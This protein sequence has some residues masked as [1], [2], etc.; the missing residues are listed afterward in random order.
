[1][2]SYN[3][4]FWSNWSYPKVLSKYHELDPHCLGLPTTEISTPVLSNTILLR[5]SSSPINVSPPG[6]LWMSLHLQVTVMTTFWMAVPESL[7][8]PSFVYGVVALCAVM[9]LIMCFLCPFLLVL[10]RRYRR[11]NR[12]LATFKVSII[13][14]KHKMYVSIYYTVTLLGSEW[15]SDVHKRRS[16][17]E[18]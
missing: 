4:F 6:I 16:N 9:V 2:R 1:M 18:T 15:W 10:W 3:G 11:R 13:I 7:S 5:S 14:H 17:R 12:Y 8:P